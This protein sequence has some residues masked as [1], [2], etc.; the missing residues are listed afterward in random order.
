MESF[1]IGF[2]IPQ[3]LSHLGGTVYVGQNSTDELFSWRY[4]SSKDVYLLEKV[5]LFI[6]NHYVMVGSQTIATF[7]F[8]RLIF[9]IFYTVQITMMNTLPPGIHY[10]YG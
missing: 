4:P 2:E 3:R 7:M 10:W 9:A 8:N 5:G 1:A 6:I